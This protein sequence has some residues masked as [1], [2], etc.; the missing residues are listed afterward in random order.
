MIGRDRRHTAPVVDPRGQQLAEVG[1]QVRRRLNM[2]LRRQDHP[3]QGD[4]VE[5]V[6]PRAR[7][8]VLH[9]RLRLGQEVLD[10]HLLDMAPPA[11][12][13]GD[14]LQ[15]L[16][17]VGPALADSHQDAGG[18]GNPEL[19]GGLQGGQTALRSLVGGS[20]V[21]VEA[22]VE[23]LDHHSLA[24]C[25]LA[26]RRQLPGVHGA[27]VGVRE[28]AGGVQ[29]AA[30]HGGHIV[31]GA[32]VAVAVEPVAGHRVAQFRPLAQREQRLM[33]ALP[34][35]GPGDLQDLFLGQVGR[36]Q[37]SRRLGEG[38]V[39]AAVAAQFSERYEDLGRVGHPGAV[40]EIPYGAG[41]RG[42]LDRIVEVVQ[43]HAGST[44]TDVAV[45]SVTGSADA[46]QHLGHDHSRRGLRI[47]GR[48]VDA[49]LRVFGLLVG[50]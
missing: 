36:F 25:H 33:A 26:Q 42:Q 43:A 38:A 22:G 44:L 48:R 23:R 24:R 39:P 50:G 29:H 6:G 28:Q 4:G 3:G 11:V 40:G 10:D 20:P 49:Q 17:A 7:R 45:A 18:V 31:D 1:G 9:A 5:V 2:H 46:C 34:G 16:D 47:V 27:G 8:P 21:G 14:G 12:P 37:P 13:L 15:G 41:L 32:G 35:T 30:G 19:A